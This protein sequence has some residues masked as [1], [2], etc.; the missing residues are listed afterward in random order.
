MNRELVMRIFKGHLQSEVATA[1]HLLKL[2]ELAEQCR[3]IVE[4][5]VNRGAS[6]SAFLLGCRGRLY[7]WDIKITKQARQLQRAAGSV[8]RLS[9]GDILDIRKLPDDVDMIFFDSLH[10]YRQLTQ[11]LTWGNHSEKYLVFHDTI[12]FGTW[13][14][15]GEKGR[16]MEQ[17]KITADFF[18]ALHGIRLAIDEFMIENPHWKIAYHAPY[19]HGL[20]VLEREN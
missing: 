9:D 12:S 19:G 16:W 11:E 7:S 18:P 5:G 3:N 8:W 4:F 6:S 17:P 13:G 2:L 1:K 15:D 10:T 20:L 14:A